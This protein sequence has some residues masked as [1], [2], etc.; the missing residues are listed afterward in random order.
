[1]EQKKTNV[2]SVWIDEEK[3]VISMQETMIGK[4]VL[5]ENRDV[6]VKVVTELVSK[7]Y[8]IG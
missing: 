3:R 5:F 8:K 7:G 6:G 1:M 4:E 2:W